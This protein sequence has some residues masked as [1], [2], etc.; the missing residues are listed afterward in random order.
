MK[1]LPIRRA[2]VPVL[3]GMGISALQTPYAQRSYVHLYGDPAPAATAEK[4]I[5]IRP[6]T[7]HVN[8][9]GGDIVQFVIDG[10]SFTWRFNVARTVSAFDLKEVAPAGLL[11]RSVMAYVSPDPR[12]FSVP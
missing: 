10:K 1:I 6:D 4:T 7:R 3:L 5:E 12:Y 11:D 2:L 8:V 9:V